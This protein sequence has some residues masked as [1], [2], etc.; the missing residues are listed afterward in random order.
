MQS[1]EIEFVDQSEVAVQTQPATQPVGN[2]LYDSL[3]LRKRCRWMAQMYVIE[4]GIENTGY[5][6][7][8]SVAY[9]FRRDGNE[10]TAAVRCHGVT[11]ENGPPDHGRIRSHSLLLSATPR[12]YILW[13]RLQRCRDQTRARNETMAA[14]R[15]HPVP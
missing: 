3:H 5:N 8:L 12:K 13:P 1:A 9:I 4:T 14:E 15:V 2:I 11:H 6:T 7:G 10:Q